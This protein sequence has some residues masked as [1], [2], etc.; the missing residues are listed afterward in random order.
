[1]LRGFDYNGPRQ[2]WEQTCKECGK[3][4]RYENRRGVK[5]YAGQRC[6]WWYWVPSL[7]SP[8]NP[9]EEPLDAFLLAVRDHAA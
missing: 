6:V 3:H 8:E 5:R 2:V 9:P 7:V 4:W 1:M